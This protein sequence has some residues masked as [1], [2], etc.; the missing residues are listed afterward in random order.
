[1]AYPAGYWAELV[2][3]SSTGRLVES[4]SGRSV[5]LRTSDGEPLEQ[6]NKLGASVWRIVADDTDEPDLIANP[7]DAMVSYRF[8]KAGEDWIPSNDGIYLASI[9]W[10]GKSTYRF[11]IQEFPPVFD[12]PTGD[13]IMGTVG[14]PISTITVPEAKGHPAPTYAVVG[15]LPK[16]VTFNSLTRQL[17]FDEDLIEAGSG[18]IRIRASSSL[19]V[20]GYDAAYWAELVLSSSQS[21]LIE[22]TNGRFVWLRTSDGEPLE[23]QFA[24]PSNINSWSDVSGDTNEPDYLNNRANVW[25]RFRKSGEE[26]IPTDRGINTSTVPW[27]GRTTYRFFTE[28]P[29]TADWTVD[30]AFLQSNVAPTAAIA[31]QPQT[32]DAGATLQLAA[33]DSDSDGSIT[34]R[35]WTGNGAFS[36]SGIRNPIWTAP[37]PSR[38]TTYTLTYTVTD[39]DGAT[40][41]VSVRITVR[42]LPVT[43][44][45]QPVKATDR[46]SRSTNIPLLIPFDLTSAAAFGGA[47]NGW[48]QWNNEGSGLD[49]NNA[50]PMYLAA[51]GGQKTVAAMIQFGGGIRLAIEPVNTIVTDMPELIILRDSDP[52]HGEIVLAPQSGTFAQ[53]RNTQQDYEVL[54]A[55]GATLTQI[56]TRGNIFTVELRGTPGVSAIELKAQPIVAL[57]KLSQPEL[58]T[59]TVLNAQAIIAVDKLGQPHLITQAIPPIVAIDK[60]GQPMIWPAA[61]MQP[62][63]ATDSFLKPGFASVLGSK[64]IVAKDLIQ[65]ARLWKA[66]RS[67][68]IVALDR[69]NKPRFETQSTGISIW[70][71]G[72]EYTAIFL[73]DVEYTEIFEGEDL[74]SG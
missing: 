48:V 60:L 16:G 52:R 61:Y 44:R 13:P 49:T 20:K 51:S 10:N 37:R 69:L 6:H 66:L 17:S 3:S 38:N 45:S 11:F 59:S 29:S 36:N 35:Q 30:Y 70:Y 34:K 15:S 2:R 47:F 19:G 74:I 73:G 71:R 4:T 56:F 27:G 14:T 21:N 54:S 9:N 12:D 67:R 25:I 39:D 22:N 7:Y 43:L 32:L 57:D 28:T 63:V 24:L 72:Q 46:L 65:R 68:P 8:R 40:A 62:L 50:V 42:A 31:T 5:W 18:T 1:M 64:P 33:T 26:W 58:H 53:R 41:S 23:Q 55:E